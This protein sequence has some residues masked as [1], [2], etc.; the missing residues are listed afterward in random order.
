MGYSKALLLV[1]FY[2]INLNFLATPAG[3]QAL[4][5]ATETIEK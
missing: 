1:Y 3:T 2:Q 5:K 4:D